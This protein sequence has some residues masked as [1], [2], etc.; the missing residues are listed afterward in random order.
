MS[1]NLSP[2]AGAGWQ[3][4]DDN[5]VPLA[6]GLLYTYTAGTSTPVATYTTL[7]GNI[8]NSNPIVLDAAGRIPYEV[9]ITS[10]ASVKFILKDSANVQI[11]SWDNIFGIN[12]FGS[13]IAD[14]YAAFANTS[15]V[16]KGDALVGFKQSNASGVYGAAVARTVHQ[17]LQEVY[18]VKDFG[19]V[20]D[21]VTDDT[22]AIQAA[23]DALGA[24]G[25]TVLIPN[26]MRCVV[27]SGLT[28]KPNV[29]IKGPNLY[30]GSP[31][32]NSSANYGLVGGALLLDGAQTIAMQGGSCLSGLLIYRKG[33]TFP[34]TSVSGWTGTAITADDDDV[35]VENCM[36][37]GFEKAFYSNGHQRP[38]LTSVYMD[39][40]NGVEIA[41]CFDIAYVNQC[42]CWPFATI[43]ASGSGA[44]LIRAGKAFYFRNGGDWNKLT[45]CFSYG[46]LRGLVIEACNSMTVTGCGFDNVPGGHPNSIGISIIGGCEDTKLLGCQTAAQDTAG[47]FI[48]NAAAYPLMTTIQNHT[49]WGGS[50]HGVLIY[51]G[52]ATILG[53]GFRGI[54]NVVS[55][56]VNSSAVFF[57]D[58]WVRD[59]TATIIN[60]SVSTANVY[61]GSNNNFTNFGGDPTSNLTLNAV[62]S[63]SSILVPN[64]GTAFYVTGTTNIGTIVHAWAGRV[65]TLLFTD[66]VSVL[67]GTA[68]V[69]GIQL[70]NNANFN[71]VSGSTLTLIGVGGESWIEIGRSV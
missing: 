48:D 17:K 37:L 63:A 43:A 41:V 16:A 61:M 10:G 36:I 68:G 33:M 69:G 1:V 67:H 49:V 52:D 20:G 55:V 53:C 56:T 60:A 18:S 8:A 31:M 66:T 42:H 23:I 29:G 70:N 47:I 6:G 39:N 40:I 12:D 38:R 30:V 3:F 58:N 44:P 7:A 4:F 2:L 51:G 71:A 28:V 19:A 62:A 65:I 11:A 50:D 46:Y 64:T 9:W 57:D 26:G 59:I 25:G 34:Q 22:G 45:N 54:D 35:F 27:D 5:G 15:D 13:Q 21:G 32:D 14:V 24:A